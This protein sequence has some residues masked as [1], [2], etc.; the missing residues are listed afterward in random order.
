KDL[1]GRIANFME[2]AKQSHSNIHL[3]LTTEKSITTDSAFTGLQ[4]LNIFRIIQEATNNALKYAKAGLI[5]IEIS[6]DG[7]NTHFLI[8]DNGKGFVEKDVE[9]GNGLLNMRKRATEL[10][11]ELLLRSGPNKGTSVSFRVKKQF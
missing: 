1:Q 9:A 3:S 10:G 4:G 11:D 5:K 6:N 7:N 2:K 8:E